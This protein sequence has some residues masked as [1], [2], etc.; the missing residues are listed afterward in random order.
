MTKSGMESVVL[1][2]IISSNGHTHMLVWYMGQSHSHAG[3]VYGAEPLTC[4]YGI[5]DRATHML[6]WYM[7]QSHSHAGMVYGATNM[8]MIVSCW[9][10]LNVSCC[11]SLYSKFPSTGRI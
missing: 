6:A 11:S 5:W 7:G 10:P 1:W 9:M 8:L 4:W 2:L 3:M